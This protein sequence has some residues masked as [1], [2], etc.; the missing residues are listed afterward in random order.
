MIITLKLKNQVPAVY[1][2]VF[3]LI[4]KRKKDNYTPTNAV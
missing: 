3:H 4:D 1:V 2:M